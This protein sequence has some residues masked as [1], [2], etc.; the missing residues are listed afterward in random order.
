MHINAK[1]QNDTSR[2]VVVE[3][4]EVAVAVVVLV[5]V[6]GI[7]VVVVLAVVVVVVIAVVV[8]VL[9][10]V[11]AEVG[12]KVPIRDTQ[13]TCQYQSYWWRYALIGSSTSSIKV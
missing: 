13:S 3:K 5:G 9:V 7:G 1:I 6:V 12:G 8:V 4:V 11:V 2:V 10:V